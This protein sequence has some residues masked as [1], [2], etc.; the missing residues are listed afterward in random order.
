MKNYFKNV[1]IKISILL[2]FLST[3]LFMFFWKFIYSI[4]GMVGKEYKL[5]YPTVTF[6]SLIFIFIVLITFILI[7]L[8]IDMLIIP[9]LRKHKTKILI[10]YFSLLFILFLNIILFL[11][12]IEWYKYIWVFTFS[13]LSI[14]SC[15]TLMVFL[16]LLICRIKK[17]PIVLSIFNS[18][19]INFY[20]NIENSSQQEQSNLSS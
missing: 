14:I 15:V 13:L 12:A 17:Q 10:A 6:G 3:I 8:L 20:E 9:K 16:L 11:T 1:I 2:S 5:F 19:D 4:Y 18:R 7:Y